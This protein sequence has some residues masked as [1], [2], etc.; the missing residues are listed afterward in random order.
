MYMGTLPDSI[1][2]ID[3]VHWTPA[4]DIA[5][6]ILDVSGVAAPVEASDISGYFHGVNLC[7]KNWREV[8]EVLN[9]FLK[10]RIE[11]IAP[12]EEWV[13]ALEESTEKAH[14]K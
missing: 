7:T 5:G 9:E 8:A 12:L 13:A 3:V 14:A 4:E 1:G 11:E 6:L 10:G 2:P